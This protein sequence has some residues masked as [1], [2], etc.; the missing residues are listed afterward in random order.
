MALNSVLLP[1]AMARVS[2]QGLAD[3][4]AAI[5]QAGLMCEADDA[6][7]EEALILMRNRLRT[8]TQLN[9]HQQQAEAMLN[10]LQPVWNYL[11]SLPGF[12]ELEEGTQND[13]TWNVFAAGLARTTQAGALPLITESIE[14]WNEV[15]RRLPAGTWQDRPS[16]TTVVTSRAYISPVSFLVLGLVCLALEGWLPSGRFRFY[17]TCVGTLA[18]AVS[19]FWWFNGIS[20]RPTEG[21]VPQA[22]GEQ[23]RLPTRVIQPSMSIPSTIQDEAMHEQGQQVT[24]SPPVGAPPLPAQVGGMSKLGSETGVASGFNIGDR[25]CLNGSK[26]YDSLAGQSGTVTRTDG[27][28]LDIT[29]D[30]GARLST[31]PIN[32]VGPYKSQA[33]VADGGAHDV[34]QYYAPFATGG[35]PTKSQAQAGRL[36][37]ALTKAAALQST[38]AAWAPLFWQSVQNERQIYG[39]DPDLQRVLESHGYFGDGTVG[40][41]RVEELKKALLEHETLGGPAHGSGGSLARLADISEGNNPEQLSWHLRLPPD[42]QRAA[43]EMYR[44]IRAEGSASVRQWINEQHPS[45]EQKQTPGYQDLYSAATI[46][47]FEL[48]ECKSESAVMHKLATSDTL[49]I[50][51][52]KLASFVYFRRTKDKTGANRMLG[53]RAPGIG[54]DIAP[55][56]MLDDANAHSKVEYQ[57]VERGHKMNRESSGQSSQSTTS[58]RRYAGKF[59]GRG[60]GGGSGKGGGRGRGGDKP[61]ATQG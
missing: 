37:E 33:S 42:L 13:L 35:L 23:H 4:V 34:S 21:G 31:V 52:R 55:K 5:Q 39:L 16:A 58:A 2:T 49:E 7:L 26:P 20:G 46:I 30:T 25:I 44:N 61:P 17:T 9:T 3:A 29:L 8:H 27:V 14:S 47:D 15:F 24:V 60:G 51:L 38:V 53:V 22:V 11:G 59:R 10:C 45:I 32:A 56:W 19:G 12:A 48:A 54:A 28:S 57:R 18:I 50:H 41:P 1:A 36:K 40:P 43:P 6:R